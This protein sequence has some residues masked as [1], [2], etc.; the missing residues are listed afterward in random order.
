M[1]T[2]V[3]V[4]AS[5]CKNRGGD[6]PCTWHCQALDEVDRQIGSIRIEENK[7]KHRREGLESLRK[8][9]T[10]PMATLKDGFV[11][12]PNLQPVIVF[13]CNEATFGYEDSEGEWIEQDGVWPFNEDYVFPDDC[14][15]FGIRVERA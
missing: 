1:P 15:R 14:E 13:D 8:K 5:R 4:L 7:L 6:C 11:F 9:L 12:D 2:Y 10:T 3:E